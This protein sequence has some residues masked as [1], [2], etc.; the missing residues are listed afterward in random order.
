MGV[1]LS[2]QKEGSDET[3]ENEKYFTPEFPLIYKTKI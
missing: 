1:L 3:V 2:V